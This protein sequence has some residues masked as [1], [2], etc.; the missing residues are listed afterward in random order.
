M[1]DGLRVAGLLWDLLAV[2]FVAIVV[3]LTD[4]LVDLG[5]LLVCFAVLQPPAT[6]FN[7]RQQVLAVGLT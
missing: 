4:R 3:R 7:P 6:G 2:L 1:T 5:T